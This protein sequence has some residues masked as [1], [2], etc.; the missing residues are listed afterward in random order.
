[1]KHFHKHYSA[2]VYRETSWGAKDYDSI[3][4]TII[5]LALCQRS[6]VR[7][8]SRQGSDSESR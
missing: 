3:K 4:H 6:T 8:G 5:G 1:M 2:F 7:A